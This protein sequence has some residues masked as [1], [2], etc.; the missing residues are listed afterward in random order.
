MMKVVKGKLVYPNGFVNGIGVE[1]FKVESLSKHI[2][3]NQRIDNGIILAPSYRHNND[4]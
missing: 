2:G 3:R 1:Y 4:K